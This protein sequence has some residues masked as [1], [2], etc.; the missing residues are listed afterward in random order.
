MD[1]VL[2][3]DLGTSGN[4]ATLYDTSGTL[5]RSEKVTY[6]TTYFGSNCAEQDPEDWWRAVCLSTKR[7]LREIDPSSIA[8]VSFSGHMMGCLPVDRD[9]RPLRMHMLYCDQRALSQVERLRD[10]IDVWEFYT[11][12][13]HR[14]S[15]SYT[16]PRVMWLQEN[17][18]DTYRATYKFLNAKDY[19]V[20]RLTGQF[21]TDYS[22]A[23]GT[24][25]FDINRLC[26]S[27]QIAQAA[28]V[29]LAKFP[30]AYESTH[31]AGEVTAAA[32]EQTGIPAGVPVC[33]GAGDGCAAGVGAGSLDDGTTYTSIGTSGWVGATSTDP[34]YDPQMRVPTFPHAVPGLYHSCGAMQT[35]GASF[36]WAAQTIFGD[37]KDYAHMDQEMEE[38]GPGSHG[39]LFLPYLMGERSPWWDD[40]ARGCFLGLQPETTQ[41]DMLRAV[42]EGVAFNLGTVL[43]VYREYIHVD[44]MMFVGGA[45]TSDLWRCI[46][47]NVYNMPVS[48][49]NNISECASMG[50]AVIGAV[51]VGLLSGFDAARPFFRA[52]S[53]QMP[54]IQTAR[55]Y[56]ERIRVFQQAYLALRE[57][58]PFL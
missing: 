26:W 57:V 13:G 29:D 38:A 18:P 30:D 36:T 16:L 35:A 22:D 37:A 20:F 41:G 50:A 58:F 47:A 53:T 2:A 10:A 45:A 6:A 7:L 49:P 24:E 42:E 12:T 11:T 34:I 15:A 33:C 48:R 54:N 46:L 39:V 17:E 56:G 25:L 23:G 3:H 5:I 14:P 21:A 43:D 19:I 51:G 44:D 52:V 31:I 32:S 55:F 9:G 8:A 4:K 40:S 27:E 1:Y 28:Q